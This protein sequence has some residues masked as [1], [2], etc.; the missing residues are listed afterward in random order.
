MLTIESVEF[1]RA[2]EIDLS[3]DE[4]QFSDSHNQRHCENSYLYPHGDGSAAQRKSKWHYSREKRTQYWCYRG[5]SCW[6]CWRCLGSGWPG[7]LFLFPTQEDEPGRLSKRSQ[8]SRKLIR[9]DGLW[10]TRDVQSAWLTRLNRQPKQQ[11]A[12]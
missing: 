9:C 7:H 2:F 6:R 11:L 4:H 8:H 12:D 5:Y 10:S 1:E 3:S